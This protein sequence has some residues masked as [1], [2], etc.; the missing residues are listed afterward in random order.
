MSVEGV[1][2]E[3]GIYEDHNGALW[4]LDDDGVWILSGD[5]D[6]RYNAEAVAVLVPFTRVTGG[7]VDADPI[8]H[9]AHYTRFPVE[10]IDITEHLSFSKGNAIKY[11][12][13]AGH[14]DA[15]KEIEDLEKAAWYIAREIER[16]KKQKE[17]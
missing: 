13:R 1:P 15:S 5:H 9:P 12:A 17:E 6:G 16:V 11:I 2:T 4:A 10:V 8:N 14:K 3:P 7:S